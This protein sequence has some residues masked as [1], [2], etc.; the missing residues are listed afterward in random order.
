MDR[1]EDLAN[2]YAF[3][4]YVKKYNSVLL[5]NEFESIL[6]KPVP[7]LSEIPL[8]PYNEILED[9]LTYLLTHDKNGNKNEPTTFFRVIYRRDDNLQ[10][11]NSYKN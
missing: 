4:N 2:K 6:N 11:E 1:K 8:P 9:S 7:K 10:F 5:F 3:D